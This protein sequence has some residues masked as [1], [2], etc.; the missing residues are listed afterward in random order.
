MN[1]EVLDS[2]VEK[3]L[4]NKVRHYELPLYLYNYSRECQFDKKWDMFTKMCRGLV[5][6]FDGNIVSRPFDK[7][8]NFEELDGTFSRIPNEDY[9]VYDKYDGSLLIVSI[10]NDNLLVHTRGSFAS[11][12]SIIGLDMINN[13]KNLK[14]YILAN[15]K[16][17]FLFE[18]IYPENKIVLDYGDSKMLVLL[19][20]INKI[21]GED[22]IPYDFIGCNTVNPLPKMSFKELKSLNLTNKEGFVIK[23]TPSNFRMK[24]KFEN[25]IELHRLRSNFSMKT[26]FDVLYTQGWDALWKS[27]TELPDEFYKQAQTYANLFGALYDEISITSEND[28]NEIM[29]LVNGNEVFNRASFAMLA[30]N[31]RYPSVLFAMLDKRDINQYVLGIIKLMIKDL[32]YKKQ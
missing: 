12:Q 27:C 16:L 31:K 15:P 20:T 24:I 4:I 26:M 28:F 3:G 25:Y 2:Y 22:K 6:D 32:E 11:D 23:F 5:L 17:T 10:Y 19:T 8:F 18:I 30:K 9:E 13:N 1:L 14:N 29:N 7:I 21:T